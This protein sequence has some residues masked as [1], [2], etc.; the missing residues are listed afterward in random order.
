MN[1]NLGQLKSELKK[2][3]LNPAD[4]NIQRLKEEKYKIA[5]NKDQNFYFL[6]DAKQVGIAP[7]WENI[8]L[9]SI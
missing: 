7:Q 2:F 4:W 9:I 1:L 5:N 8:Q 3:G 6:G